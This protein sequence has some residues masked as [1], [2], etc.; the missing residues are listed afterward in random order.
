[1]KTKRLF[2]LIL[3]FILILT[4]LPVTVSAEDLP[5]IEHEPPVVEYVPGEI[6]I[7]TSDELIDSS[8]TFITYGSDEEYTPINFEEENIESLKELNTYDKTSNERTYVIEVEGNV[9]EKC[10]E[11]EQLPGVICAEPNLIFHTMEFTMPREIQYG[12]LYNQHM[13]WYFDLMEI[14]ATWQEFEST[15]EGVVVAVIDNGFKIDATDFP[16]K[17]WTDSNGNHGWNTYKNSADI[18]PI[19]KNDGT[20]FDNSDHGT[21]VAGI[22][23][24]TANGSNLIG[25]AYNSEIML[26]NAA[27]YI[28]DTKSPQFTID[29]IIEAIDYARSN[30]ADIINLSLG[31]YGGSTQLENA[32]NKAY[33]EGIAIIAAAGNDGVSASV[34]EVYPASYEN[35]IGVM[36]TDKTNTSQL[37]SFSNY[38][39]TGKYY[40]IAAPGYQILSCSIESGKVAY[41]SGT[42]Q[43]SPLVAACAALYLSEYPDTSIEDLYEAIKNSPNTFV[44]SNSTT[45]PND[46]Y[47]FK[48]LNAYNLLCYGKTEPDIKLNINTNVTRDESLGYIWGLDEG[49]TDINN[50]ITV[51]EGTGTLEFIPTDNGVGTGSV[52]N[53]YD[54]YGN[55]F[56]TYTIIIFGDINGDAT[57]DGQDAV[58]ISCIINFTEKFSEAQIFASDVDFDGNVTEY[59]Y[60]I[61]ANTALFLDFVSQI[62]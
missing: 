61:T 45:V 15:G 9:E 36:A 29:D 56:K 49:F 2:N 22:V 25:A 6:V 31:A 26:I 28:S 53:I 4:N 13:K 50:F 57:V 38:D 27:H 5:I 35:V 20:A 40:D 12:S 32:I 17:L 10:K 37:A 33:S 3:C 21:H 39:P 52:L 42:S 11:L 54:I 1:M 60:N 41:G 59:D 44:K 55:L 14:P 7:T 46:T 24:A 19:Y 8:S 16:K 30:G 18:S 51:T 58:I 62:K 34:S 43:A 23:G 47:S 48:F